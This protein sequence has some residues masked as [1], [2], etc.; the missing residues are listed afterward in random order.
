MCLPKGSQPGDVLRLREKGIPRLRGQGR[1]D[2]VVFVD[3]RVPTGLSREQEKLLR[4]FARLRMEE[5]NEKSHPWGFFTRKKH[6]DHYA[7]N[8]VN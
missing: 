7:G 6:E 2:Q 5:R 4:E 1:G 3:V 8:S